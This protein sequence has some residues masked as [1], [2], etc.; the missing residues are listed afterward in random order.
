[1]LHNSS[2]LNKKKNSIFL[3]KNSTLYFTV[4]VGY[5]PSRTFISTTFPKIYA[6]VSYRHLLILCSKLSTKQP[7]PMIL[8]PT[9]PR[10]HPPCVTLTYPFHRIIF[11]HVP[12]QT[13]FLVPPPFY[14]FLVPNC[15]KSRNS[16]PKIYPNTK[17]KT[18][19][20]VSI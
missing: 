6:N 5:L 2:I 14:I 19:L 12:N 11:L 20:F 8:S 15:L 13:P 9:S 1:M 18:K 4:H 10:A 3:K 7:F 17:V 16:N